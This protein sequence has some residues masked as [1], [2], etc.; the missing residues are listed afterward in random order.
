MT[1]RAIRG[2]IQLE[3]DDRNHLVGSTKDLLKAML[4]ANGLERRNLISVVFTATPDLRSEFPAVAARELGI[5]DTPLL[6]TR[7]IDVEGALPRVVRILV[8]AETDRP[9]CDVRHVYLGGA[10]TLRTDLADALE[11]TR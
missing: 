9:K 2:A 5:T 10:A 6:C 3:R 11:E 8:H 4:D 7:E 1:V